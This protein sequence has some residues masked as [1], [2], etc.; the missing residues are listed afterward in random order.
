MATYTPMFIVPHF[1]KAMVY[2][3][4][5]ILVLGPMFVPIFLIFESYNSAKYYG[6]IPSTNGEGCFYFTV[7]TMQWMMLAGATAMYAIDRMQEKE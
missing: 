2:H 7:Q 5:Y 1:L 4:M 6:F 3:V